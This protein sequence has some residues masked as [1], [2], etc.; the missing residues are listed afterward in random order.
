M[1]QSMLIIALI[2]TIDDDDVFAGLK[3]KKKKSAMKAVETVLGEDGTAEA[4]QTADDDELLFSELK[5]KKKK[6]KK[7][8]AFEEDLGIQE[9]DNAGKAGQANDSNAI[10]N[11]HLHERVHF[12]SDEQSVSL[13]FTIIRRHGLDRLKS[14]LH[15]WRASAAGLSSCAAE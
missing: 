15:V 7:S 5:K 1:A 12:S 13:P 10:G 9:D 6:S 14:R 8:A 2:M 3:K 11:L 4:L